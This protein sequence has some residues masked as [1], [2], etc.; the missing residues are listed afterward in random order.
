LYWKIA[1]WLFYD[2]E[3]EKPDVYHGVKEG[4]V[5]FLDGFKNEWTGSPW[6]GRP[7]RGGLLGGFSPVVFT[8]LCFLFL[9]LL[10]SGMNG[11]YVYDWFMVIDLCLYFTWVCFRQNRHAL[12]MAAF[13]SKKNYTVREKELYQ[14]AFKYWPTRVSRWIAPWLGVFYYF[15]FKKVIDGLPEYRCL[16]CD[17]PM[18]KDDS[19]VLSE[20]HERETKLG[21]LRFE[22]CRCSNGHVFVMVEK[23][24][25]F[26]DYSKCPNCHAYALKL[27]DTKILKEASRW[28]CGTKEMT[29]VCQHC[30]RTVIDTIEFKK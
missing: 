25:R 20:T 30:D 4:E 10:P 11:D 26:D 13:M 17:E 1:R 8:V 24:D 5:T 3:P 21:S 6:W 18:E 2:Q 7:R 22:P 9:F 27:T 29:S 16:T 23:G 19:F 28:H 15:K 14:K 12:K